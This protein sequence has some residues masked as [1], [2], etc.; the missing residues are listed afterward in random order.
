[1]EKIKADIL[2][3]GDLICKQTL[4]GGGKIYP[5]G[6]ENLDE[7]FD[8]DNA[9]VINGDV[10]VDSFDSKQYTVVV[11]GSIAAKGGNDGSL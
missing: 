1:M 6:K 8:Y 11:T 4:I 3:N 9:L 5:C 10:A 7:W 2:I